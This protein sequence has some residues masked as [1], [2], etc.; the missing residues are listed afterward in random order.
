MDTLYRND[1]PGAYPESWYAASTEIPPPR[2]PLDGDTRADVC[3]VGAGYTGLS[4]ALALAERGLSV[5]VLDAHRAGF[6]GSGRN[7]GQ[8]GSGFNKSQRW[9]EAR[10]GQDT[11]RALWDI[12]EAAKDQ[13]R[14]LSARHAPEANFRPGVAHGAYSAAEAREM[15]EDAEHLA[16]RYGYDRIEPLDESAMRDLVKTPLY[17]GGEIDR[18]AGHIHPLRYALGLARAAEA[19]GARIC[20]LTEATGLA[21]GAPV[22]VTTP[23]GTVTA[24][25][26]ILAGNG[27]MPDLSPRVAA[28]VMP[29]NSFI[30]ATEPLADPRAVLA[31][32][33]AVADSKFVVNYYRMEEGGRFL[34]GG[35]ESYTLGFPTDIRSAL[36]RRMATLF[37]QLEGTPVTHVWGGTLGITMTR[38]PMVAR[39]GRNT[40]NA[41]GFSGHGVALSGFAGTVMA[42]A[43]AGQA[44]RFDV[45]SRL[46]IPAFPGG[47]GFR[48]PLLT[49]AMSWY[50]LRDRLGI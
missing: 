21:D 40:L 44:G 16:R 38:L 43:I 18:G 12:A 35:R 49:L 34:F 37:P 7:G 29:I 41:S 17:K 39:V 20:E 48:A 50:A 31:E 24:D 26:A 1:R 33:I 8:V 46:P 13:V 27:Y 2:P 9:L 36:L 5:V 3:I 6:G 11:A 22:R 19:A 28:R 10:L 23:H 25:H 47:A 15:A 42:E 30:A 14:T 4:A 32:D 45:M